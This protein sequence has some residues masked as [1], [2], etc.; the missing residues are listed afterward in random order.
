MEPLR[1][2]DCGKLFE[3]GESLY[4]KPVP[5]LEYMDGKE[6]ILEPY[7]KYCITSH[8]VGMKGMT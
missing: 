6:V 4:F 1:C 7:C 3:H 5:Y 2:G 8:S